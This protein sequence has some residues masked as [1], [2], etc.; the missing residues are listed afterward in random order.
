MTPQLWWLVA[1]AGGLVA[2]ALLTASVLAGL[3]LVVRLRRLPPAAWLLDLHRFLG[4]L[5]VAFTG[6]HLVALLLDDFVHFTPVH[7]LVPFTSTWRPVAVAWG[8]LALHLL[9]AVEITSL[10]R[11]RMPRRVWRAV[12]LTSFPAWALASVHTLTAGTDATAWP[13]RVLLAAGVVLVAGVGT[14]RLRDA[15]RSVRSPRQ[16]VGR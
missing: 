6:L 4:G 2:Y 9:V 14:W 16:E 5:A 15:S 12:H 8:V 7:L 11:S 13:V 1:R 3:L 10:I